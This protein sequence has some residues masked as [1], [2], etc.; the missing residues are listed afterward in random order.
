LSVMALAVLP[1]ADGVHAASFDCSKASSRQVKLICEDAELST[2]DEHLARYYQAARTVLGRG[3]ECLKTEQRE[4]LA[5]VRSGCSDGDCLP[6]VYLARL[7]ELDGLQP[8]AT[9]I[10]DMELP[11]GRQ[12]SGILAPAADEV[13]APRTS[14]SAPVE[15]SGRI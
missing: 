2:L 8:G 12:M 1:N 14:A 3:G 9:A 10:Q 4:W 5:K 11:R 15:V 13:A 6:S 7:R